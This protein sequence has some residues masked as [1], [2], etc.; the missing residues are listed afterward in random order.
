MI[1]W[2]DYI[3]LKENKYSK[4]Y[5][6]L[7]E[8]AQSRVLPKEVYTEGHH[9]IPKSWG[10]IDKKINIVRLTAKEHYMAHAFLWKMNVGEGFH[11]KMVHAF[12]AMSIM[13]DGSYNKPGYR[14]NS[15]LFQSVKLERIA[16]LKTLRGP[17]S[18]AYGKKL[19]ISEKGKLNRKKAQEEFWNDP[20]RV[21][22]RNENLRKAQQTPEAIAKRKALADSRRGIKR[23]PVIIEKSA[24]KRRGRKGTEL[25]SQQALENMR[26]GNKNK[27]YS[28]EA[29]EKMREVARMNGS[30]PK[31]EEHKRRI[32]ESNKKIDRWWTKGENNPN[33]GK[34]MLPHVKEKL[35][36]ANQ[37]KYEERKA[38]MFV[39]PVKPTGTFTFRGVVYKSISEASRQT[40]FSQRI[41]TT[42]VKYWGEN[43]DQETIRKIDNGELKYPRVAPNKGVPMSEEQRLAIKETKLIKF[44]K[45]KEAGLPNPNTGRKASEETRKKIAERAKGR[46]ASEETRKIL[47]RASKGKS[48]SP[49]HIE[50]IRLAKLAKKVKTLLT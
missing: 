41:M 46:K 43:P 13:K 9:I 17:L 31:S 38:K 34:T 22:R 19:N 21:A 23:D 14:I 50:A 40:G 47:S 10:G 26:Q 27:T 42:Q 30:R 16:H 18:P 7:I 32:S 39:G 49:A 5:A 29:K 12:N 37:K 25:F 33:Y 4:W 2:P 8:K 35:K 24:S 20:E 44:Q 45:L 11:N 3:K 28:P 1:N 6:E 48:K 15:R 36:E